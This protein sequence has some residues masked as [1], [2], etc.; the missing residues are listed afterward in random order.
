MDSVTLGG[1]LLAIV[2]GAAGGLGGQLWAGV[3]DLVRRPFHGSHRLG[4]TT[5]PASSGE[6]ELIALEHGL[7]DEAQAVALAVTL[8]SRAEEDARF[9]RDL[10]G[11]W[12]RANRALARTGGVTNTIS[13][14]NQQGPVLQGRDFSGLTFGSTAANSPPH[15]TPQN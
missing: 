11:W 3:S 10:E 9:L 12:A 8:I 4:N 5:T 1:I 6:A 15:T 7:G 14:G 2:S 13:G